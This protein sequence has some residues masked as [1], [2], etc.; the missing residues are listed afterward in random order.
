MQVALLF[1]FASYM[2]YGSEVLV[3]HVDGEPADPPIR[4]TTGPGRDYD[5]AI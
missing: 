2:H 5:Y 3:T 4:A 1:R